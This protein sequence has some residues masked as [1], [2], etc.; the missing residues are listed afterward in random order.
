M[1]P[2]IRSLSRCIS[3]LHPCLNDQ[4]GTCKAGILR[5]IIRVVSEL[6]SALAILKIGDRVGIGWQGRSY[7]LC[8]WRKQGEVQLCENIDV[9]GVWKPYG[10]FASSVK[11]DEQFAY[12]LPA[13]TPSEVG[14]VLDFAQTYMQF[15]PPLS[16]YPCVR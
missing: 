9:C 3:G 13:A 12:P 6:G 11:E 5:E 15:T 4:F 16:S 1:E 10:S 7:G 2:K 14:S 8:E